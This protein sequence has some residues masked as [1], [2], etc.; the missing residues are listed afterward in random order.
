MSFYNSRQEED[1]S[2]TVPAAHLHAGA[3]YRLNDRTLLGL[4]LSYS[5]LGAIEASGIY[6]SHP[7]HAEDPEL[8]NHNGFTGARDWTLA[9]TFKRR[10]GN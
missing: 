3:D 10:F 4:R 9:L 5:M 1:I 2:D 7:W 6:A 8:R